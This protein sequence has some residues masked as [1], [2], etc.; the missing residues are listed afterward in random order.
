MRQVMTGEASEEKSRKKD[1]FVS[2]IEGLIFPFFYLI[3]RKT[4]S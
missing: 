2:E 1:D 3:T 4:I